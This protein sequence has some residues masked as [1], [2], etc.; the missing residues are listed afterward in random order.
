VHAEL[1]VAD[2]GPGIPPH[3][4]PLVFERFYRSTAARA[5]PG[6]GLGLAIVKQVVLKHGGALRVDD[7]VPGADPPGTA[8]R[9]VLPG[10]P[11]ADAAIQSSPIPA[12][13]PAGR[14]GKR[15]AGAENV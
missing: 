2:Q 7:A 10:R 15:A 9:V 4:K 6:S 13:R 1:V 12:T 5:M 8:F 14:A 3:E 11:V